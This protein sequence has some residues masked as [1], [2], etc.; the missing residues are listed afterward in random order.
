MSH[1]DIARGFVKGD[2]VKVDALWKEVLTELNLHG[3]PQKDISGRK[4]VWMDWR[5]FI[6]KKVAHN[7]LEARATGGGPFNKHILTPTEDT[8]PQLYGIYVVATTL[9]KCS[10]DE[11]PSLL[12]FPLSFVSAPA[13]SVMHTED[14]P[15]LSF[16]LAKHTRVL[17]TRAI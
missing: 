3:A 2:K 1:K 8:I 11:F 12:T 10:P 5:A 13:L 16:A 15:F 7:N 4:K 17:M 14:I 9:P 6:R